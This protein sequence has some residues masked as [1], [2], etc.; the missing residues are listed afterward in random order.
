M[1]GGM[2]GSVQSAIDYAAARAGPATPYLVRIAPGAYT[3][4]VTLKDYVDVEGSGE[5]VTV[6]RAD[7]PGGTIV[8]GANAEVRRLTVVNNAALGASSYPDGATI[9]QTSGSS[10]FSHVT[11][12]MAGP[13]EMS[14][15]VYILGGVARFDHATLT[16]SGGSV[17]AYAAYARDAGALTLVDSTLN[18]QSTLSAVGAVALTGGSIQLRGCEVRSSAEYAHG[19]G[20]TD[21][22]VTLAQSTVTV[23]GSEDSIGAHLWSGSID[24]DGVTLASGGGSTRTIVVDE[25][26]LNV[27]ASRV[28]SPAGLYHGAVAVY[29]G[30]VRFA[31]T[32]IVGPI[33]GSMTCLG[34]Y[35]GN[36]M[37][38][39]C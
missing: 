20:T 12:M 32:Q 24:M 38:L 34:T 6:L 14:L 13:G 28:L 22:A 18:A 26:N 8:A 31:H 39:A 29:G 15:V 1:S 25:G 3:G 11:A 21:G 17:I 5:G 36:M 10:R 9:M 27:R 35:D 2:F 4:Q 7:T 23:S 16:A 37:P 30:T 33:A 19:V